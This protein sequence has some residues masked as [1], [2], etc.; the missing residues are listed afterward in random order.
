[1]KPY[2]R[3]VRYL[4]EYAIFI[5][6][7]KLLQQFNISRA[8]SFCACLTRLIGPLL[9]V[10]NLARRNIKYVGLEKSDKKI[11]SMLSDAW[12]NFGRFIG[13]FAHLSKL[14]DDQL[15][16]MIELDN[17][18]KL[19]SLCETNQP[20]I[21]FTGHFANW[22]LALSQMSKLGKELSVVYRKANN[23]YVD[24][25]IRST[26]TRSNIHLI[27]K[28]PHGFKQLIRSIK[29]GRP[30]IMLVDQRMN[31]GIQV[32]FMGKPAMTAD[33]IARLAI[34]FNYKIIPAQIIRQGQCSKFKAIIQ[35]E[36]EISKTGDIERDVYNIIE[37][38]NIIIEG[39]VREHPTQWFW[40]H[41]R[42]GIR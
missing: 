15:S 42:W 12:D 6:L 21:L 9:S 36:I 38:I 2:L 20:F 32:P 5:T 13:E 4:A 28:G 26:R 19:V 41:N 34:Q 30:I 31:E 18:Q 8:A 7:F 17:M 11:D 22:D 16:Q 24:K 39:W 25:I 23:P 33:A 29:A 37:K 1:M 10:S 40:F 35:P 14:T 27:E 3:K